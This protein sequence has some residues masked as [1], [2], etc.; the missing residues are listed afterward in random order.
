MS[1]PKISVMKTSNKTSFLSFKK[2]IPFLAI[3]LFVCIFFYP[4]FQ[5]KVPIPGDFVLGIYSPWKDHLWS[6][7][8]GHVPVKNPILADVVS[9]TYP[10]QTLAIDLMKSGQAPIWNP[11]IFGG[12]PLLANFQSALFAITNIVYLFVS[13]IDGWS[14]R[15]ILQHFLAALFTYFL[16]RHWKVSKLGSIFGGLLFAFSGFNLIWSQ[17][18]AHTLTAAFIP[19]IFLLEDKLLEDG[20]VKDGAI[21]SLCIALQFMSGY[22]QVVIYTLGAISLLWI[23]KI[24][25]SKQYL[26]KSLKLFIFVFFGITGAAVQLLPA[27]ELLNLSQRSTEPHPY[28][29]AFLPFQKIITFIA[30]D[31]FGNHATNNWWGPQDYT[32]NTG[33]VG[34]ISFLLALFGF[35]SKNKKKIFIII[36]F[37]ISLLLSFPTFISVTLWKSGILGL[38]AASAHRALVLMNLSVSTLAAFGIDKYLES[39]K[40]RLYLLG[41]IPF[42]VLS[43]YLGL[44]FT[45]N[46]EKHQVV[47]LANLVL[48]YVFLLVTVTLLFIGR[49]VLVVKKTFTVVVCILA[50][51]ELFVFGWKFTPFVYKNVVFPLTPA[52]S[53]LQSI[54]VPYRTT[55]AHTV[56]INLRMNYK[57][58]SLEGYDAVY[59]ESFSK[60][61]TVLN[62]GDPNSTTLGRYGFVN[63]DNA[64]LLNLANVSY[65]LE[66]R[67]DSTGKLS[68]FQNGKYELIK[69]SEPNLLIYKN[70][71]ALPRSMMFY[72]WEV[73]SN[74]SALEV[75]PNYAFSKKLIINKDISINKSS[76]GEGTVNYLQNEATYIKM[77][78]STNK[79][80]LLFTSDTFYPGWLAKVDGN[81]TDI[82]QA[83]YAFRAIQ[84]PKGE[85]VVEYIYKPSSFYT[86]LKISI[87]SLLFLLFLILLPVSFW[88]RDAS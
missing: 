5:G 13:T 36:L 19:L 18:N 11:Y 65:V 23:Y 32:S 88:R 41:L 44:T 69:T 55:G 62:G 75:L 16:L 57:I 14:L 85:H 53:Y 1:V 7:Y 66:S 68:K 3:V 29:W 25:F 51:F 33:Y 79:D 22:P 84:V 58:P 24:K 12:A 38:Q 86:G 54:E 63:D 26:L 76:E 47:A 15:I 82:L 80:G 43:I 56:P 78:V 67:E 81:I 42:I 48:P 77:E 2:L 21:L 87:I 49:R 73:L 4:V 28:S 34:I 64:Q 40:E 37:V 61:L 74:P 60:F 20:K 46:Y 9:F 30:P 10:M 45:G 39:K 27:K 6:G 8:P 17:W 52:L 31:Y 59:P 72:D 70:L 50:V 83:D 35:F 71:E